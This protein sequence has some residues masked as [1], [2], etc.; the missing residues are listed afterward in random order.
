MQTQQAKSKTDAAIQNLAG[1]IVAQIGPLEVQRRHAEKMLEKLYGE[2]EM[3][4]HSQGISN[5]VEADLQS[6]LGK[7]RASIEKME[8][9]R[10]RE[11]VPAAEPTPIA[12]APVKA[13]KK[14]KGKKKPAKKR[15]IAA[16]ESTPRKRGRPPGSKNRRDEMSAPIVPL[17]ASAH[18][19]NGAGPVALAN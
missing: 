9:K 4:G 6:E 2:L 15:P 12:A 3:L 14:N 7:A 8:A 19:S 1:S 18:K 11:S 5:T 13:P 10:V 16:A 17:V